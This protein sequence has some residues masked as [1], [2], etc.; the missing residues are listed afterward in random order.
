MTPCS[1]PSILASLDPDQRAAAADASTARCSSSPVR[2]PARPACS[3]TASPIWSPSAASQPPALPRRHLHPPRGGRDARAARRSAWRARRQTSRSTPSIRSASRS[4]ARIRRQPACSAASASPTT[5]SASRC[6]AK[7]SMSRTQGRALLARS[8]RRSARPAADGELAEAAAA[9]AAR[10]RAQLD[11]LR[12][13]LGLALRALLGPIPSCRHCRDR[14]RWISVDEFQDVDEQQY[15]LVRLLAPPGAN[16]CVI[17]DPDQAIYGFR[18]ADAACFARFRS[19]YAPRSVQ[20]HAT[21]A[22]P[23]RSSRPRRR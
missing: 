5:K 11:R 14:F 22:R 20:L 8:P 4:C 19:D 10:W 12:R 16:L 13:S 1:V 18:G 6:C 3:R 9:Y 23:A 15:R 21:T 7:R 17:G 2:A